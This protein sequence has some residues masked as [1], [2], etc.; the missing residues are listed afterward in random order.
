MSGWV[1]TKYGL[2]ALAR[3][4]CRLPKL[5]T[6]VKTKMK[7]YYKFENGE[8]L[9][10][11]FPIHQETDNFYDFESWWKGVSD[12]PPVSLHMEIVHAITKLSYKEVR[13]SVV[14]EDYMGAPGVA[15]IS[16][17]EYKKKAKRKIKQSL[18]KKKG[19]DSDD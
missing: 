2:P 15:F 18:R 1:L 5:G 4:R 13:E 19:G 16:D 8:I 10:V 14:I 3:C 9:E 12:A 7:Y 6:T 17:K 11:P